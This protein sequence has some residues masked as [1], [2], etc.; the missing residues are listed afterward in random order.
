MI[1][2]LYP[3][4]EVIV[5]RKHNTTIKS[6]CLV[7]LALTAFCLF[8]TGCNQAKNEDSETNIVS[9]DSGVPTSGD[10]GLGGNQLKNENDKLLINSIN[11]AKTI[12]D[13]DYFLSERSNDPDIY[14]VE[15]YIEVLRNGFTTVTGNVTNINSVAIEED[16]CTLFI[17]TFDI[18]IDKSINRNIDSTTVSCITICKFYGDISDTDSKCGLTNVAYDIMNN[19]TGFFVLQ[20]IGDDVLSINEKIYNI[21]DFADFYVGVR[22]DCTEEEFYYYGSSISFKDIK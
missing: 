22:Y 8:V 19:P 13:G 6:V 1:A 9:S 21:S 20:D 5:M 17:T 7:I 15:E 14:T 4:L 16:E 18:N 10:H 2:N 12:K 3:V 11:N